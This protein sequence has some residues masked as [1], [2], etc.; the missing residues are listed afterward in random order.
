MGLFQG[1]LWKAGHSGKTNWDSGQVLIL[2]NGM[3]S[4]A[5]ETRGKA[6]DSALR[7]AYTAL[8]DKALVKQVSKPT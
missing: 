7:A 6:K 4:A 8:E 5:D 3:S 2:D 1:R